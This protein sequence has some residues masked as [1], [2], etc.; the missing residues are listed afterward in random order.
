MPIRL[1]HW[2]LVILVIISILT[3]LGWSSLS[4]ETMVH[5]WSGIS[6]LVFVFFR[7]L[8]GF[9]GVIGPAAGGDAFLLILF[10]S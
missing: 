4:N 3:G 7:I 6:I 1:F 9:F 5:E 2:V 10:K 8:W